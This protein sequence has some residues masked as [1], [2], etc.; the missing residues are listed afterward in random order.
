ML[1]YS[2]TE[3]LYQSLLGQF[4]END[5]GVIRVGANLT[6]AQKRK[7]LIIKWITPSTLFSH[8]F[9]HQLLPKLPKNPAYSLLAL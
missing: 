8:V 1:S 9:F 4:N 6:P 3:Q 7:L 5:H 2:L